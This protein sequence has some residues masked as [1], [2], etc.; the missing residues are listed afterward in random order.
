[1]QEKGNAVKS[2]IHSKMG[3]LFFARSLNSF[4]NSLAI[5]CNIKVILFLFN[6]DIKI[7][8]FLRR[9][10]HKVRLVIDFFKKK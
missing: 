7:D 3:R 6:L 10:Y 5:S 2:K 8:L 1:M 4:T 9:N